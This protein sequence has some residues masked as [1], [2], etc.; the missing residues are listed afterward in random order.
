MAELFS[1]DKRTISEHIRNILSEGKLHEDSVLRNFRTTAPD[2]KDYN[3][4]LYNLVK[5]S[6]RFFF[7]SF[8][9]LR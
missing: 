7:A 8:A 4:N 1:K 2:G 5:N 3:V 6:I 9:S